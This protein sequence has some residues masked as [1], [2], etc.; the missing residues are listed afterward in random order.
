[1]RFEIDNGEYVGT[2]E[3][4]GPGTVAVRM[5]KPRDQEFFESYFKSERSQLAP[6][7]D[8][9]GMTYERPCD[10]EAAFNRALYELSAY[11]YKVCAGYGR[12][13]KSRRSQPA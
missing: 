8:H 5:K 7:G 13:K 3:W 6:A 4:Q 11:A 2:V 10:S 12:R 9:E 1:M